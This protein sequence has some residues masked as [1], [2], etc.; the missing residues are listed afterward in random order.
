M[1]F[2]RGSRS[3]SAAAAAPGGRAAGGQPRPPRQPRRWHRRGSAPQ[4]AAVPVLLGPDCHISAPES[5]PLGVSRGCAASPRR[6]HQQ[7]ELWRAEERTPRSRRGRLPVGGL[8]VPWRG[9]SRKAARTVLPLLLVAPLARNSRVACARVMAGAMGWRSREGPQ[10]PSQPWDSVLRLLPEAVE[11]RA[12]VRPK[13]RSRSQIACMFLN[14][15][16]EWRLPFIPPPPPAP[17][18]LCALLAF[19]P[20]PV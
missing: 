4:P 8:P 10:G 20:N 11:T 1:R 2:Q 17:R 16:T 13:G 19:C 6:C 9:A 3:P 7:W 5:L 12:R 18:A 14:S 15:F